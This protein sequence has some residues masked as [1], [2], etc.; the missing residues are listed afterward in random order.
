MPST[1]DSIDTARTEVIVPARQPP[2]RDVDAVS[3]ASAPRRNRIESI[4]LL[5]GLIMAIMML[6]HTRDFVHFQ[7]F[8]FDP[9]DPARTD[10]VLFFTRWITHFCAPVFVFLAG[11]GAYLQH[12]RGKSREELSRFLVARGIWFVAFEVVVLRLVIFL[13][14][15]YQVLLAFLQVIWAIGWGLVFLAAIIHL[16]LRAIVVVSIGIIAGHNLLD[17]VRVTSGGGPGIVL[18]GAL[19]AIWKILHE[20]GFIFPFGTPGS[21]VL[22]MYPLIP[23]VA[24]MSAGYA[25]GALYK[26]SETERRQ[27]LF[28]LG[29]ALALGFVVVRAINMYGDP[30]RWSAQATTMKTVFSFLALS[31]YPPSLLYLMMTLGPALMFLGWSE[32]HTQNRFAKILITYGK[33][34]LFFYVLQWIVAHGFAILASQLA[35]KST[36]YLFG[37]LF[38][39]PPPPAGYGFGMAVVY[40]LWLLGLI[41]LYP[42]CRWFADV[43]A[44]RRDWWLSYL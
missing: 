28:R 12:M 1:M 44:R 38:L 15:D 29:A 23:W 31:K 22:V 3:R 35:G 21:A 11:T 30:V 34:P 4:D 10:T 42:L 27:L 39:S 40:A 20:R 2:P 5:R 16:P 7:A 14:A 25:F 24:V 36:D 8:D 33:V 18:P 9:T 37:N 6:D 17:G 43:K 13:N 26:W 19:V 41:L 32:R